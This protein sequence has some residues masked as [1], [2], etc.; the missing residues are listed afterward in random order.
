MCRIFFFSVIFF[1]YSMTLLGNEVYKGEPIDFSRGRLVVHENKRFICH[2]DGTPFF[3]LGDTAWELFHRLNEEEAERYLENR[4]QKGFTVIQAVILAEEDGLNTPN[5]NNDSPLFD[6]DPLKPNEAYFAFVDEVIRMTE[7]KGMYMGLLPT[8][9]DKVD[10]AW[11]QGPVVFNEE[12][13]FLYG[14]YL[15]R[16]YAGFRNIIWIMGGDRSGG[17]DNTAVWD[18]MARGIKSEDTNH[19]MTFHSLGRNTSSAWFH[20]REW[21]DFNSAHTGHHHY[22][23]DI[24]EK[25]ISGDY[26]REPT[27]PIINL[28]PCYEDHPVRSQPKG[29]SLWFDDASVRHAMYWSLF[30]GAF[31]HV[32]GCHPIW[33]FAVPGQARYETRNNWYDVLDMDGA[34]DMQHGRKLMESYDFFSRQPADNVILTPQTDIKDYAVA[35]S[36]KDYSLVYLPFGNSIDV[37]LETIPEAKRL[38]LFWFDPRTGGKK[39]IKRTRAKGLFKATPPT[40]GAGCDWILIVEKAGFSW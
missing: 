29:V 12:N 24:F 39:F 32:Y 16:R 9:G 15:G 5:R 4:R 2:E 25:L 35:T 14:Q 21:L 13:A 31:G 37:S 40:S 18:A 38:K 27:K 33:Q 34:W 23:F 8:W 30:S 7:K 22:T 36:G 1:F 19:L 17:G 20:D 3:Y 6:N 10:R 28:E 11:G 26:S